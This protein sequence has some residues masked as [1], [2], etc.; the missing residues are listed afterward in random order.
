MNEKMKKNYLVTGAS[1]GI[2]LA[3]TQQ[4][5]NQGEL[6]TGIARRTEKTFD[7][8]NYSGF[9]LDFEKQTDLESGFKNILKSQDSWD[10]LI[11]AAGYGQFSFIEQFSFAQMQNIMNVN[12]MAHALLVKLM[13][14]CLKKNKKGHVVF[15]GS[16]SALEGGKNGA[17]YCA[18]KFAIRG[19]AQALRE[20][21]AKSGINIS[22]VNPGMVKTPFFESLNFRPGNAEENYIEPG[23]VASTVQSILSMRAGTNIDEVNLSPLKHVIDFD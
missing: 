13:L 14:P 11:C 17:M 3:I 9:S 6:V 15:I 18:S 5:L 23:D 16:E 22:V 12:F 20:E 1:S 4:L 10:G 19:F 7:C 8:E 21:C 2:G